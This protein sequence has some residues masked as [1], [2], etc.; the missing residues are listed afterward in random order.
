M[1]R[2]QPHIVITWLLFAAIIGGYLLMAVKFPRAYIVAT[3]EDLLGEWTQVFLFAATM[4]LSARLACYKFRQRWFF[5]LLALACF[6]VVGEEISWGQRIFNIATPEFF[7]QHNLQNETNL[8]NFFTGPIKSTGKMLLEYLLAAGMVGYGLVYPL[9]MKN[10]RQPALWLYGKGVPFPPLYL[11]PFFT[12]SALF[13]LG[14][15]Q[16]N[17]AEIAELLIPLALSLM[18]LNYVQAAHRQQ[19]FAELS[20][21]PLKLSRQLR[22]QTLLLVTT[23]FLL[24]CATTAACYFSPRL[25]PGVRD[26]FA[27]GIE[28][29]AGR[30]QR[31]QNWP[32]AAR[33]YRQLQQQDPAR[34]DILRHL[35]RVYTQMGEADQAEQY[36]QQA[37]QSDLDYLAHT[38]LSVAAHLSLAT[39]YE[40]MGQPMAATDH[41]QGSLEI[42][43]L[44]FKR[45]P[46]NPVA[47]YWLGRALEGTAAP[48][49]ALQAYH[50]ALELDPGSLKARK[51]IQR[52]TAAEPTE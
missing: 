32:V 19:D 11:W 23:V 30:Y 3:Y 22:R 51:A 25:G 26:R 42:A 21:W 49:E 13:E 39:T 14:L 9:L 18:A 40:L 50:R 24:A 20:Q 36:L 38:P 8:H 15:F 46:Q 4:L 16:F 7:Q 33:L 5:A 10:G 2:T 43:Q 47:A 41:L 37:E 44:N 48:T 27:N 31:Q 12:A 34:A 6:Y 29:F 17:E 35:F 1:T 45:A 52:L 28:K